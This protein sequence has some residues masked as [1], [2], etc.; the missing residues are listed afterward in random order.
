MQLLLVKT[1]LGNKTFAH[2]MIFVCVT[3]H[4]HFVANSSHLNVIWLKS[5]LNYTLK[6][7][8]QHKKRHIFM[9]YGYIFH[10]GIH[11]GRGLIWMLKFHS[12]FIGQRS[13]QSS[14]ATPTFAQHSIIYNLYVR[15]AFFF[16][17]K[18]FIINEIQN[19]RGEKKYYCNRFEYGIYLTDFS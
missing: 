11:F 3:H 5:R 18:I 13:I 7:K 6:S 9:V 1:K 19:E 17:H 14:T 8:Q 4:L 15:A 2:S 12:K 16:S 10:V